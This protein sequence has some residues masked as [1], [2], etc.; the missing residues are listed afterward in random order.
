[1]NKDVLIS[2]NGLQVAEGTDDSVEVVTVGEY[3]NRNDKHYI[4]YEDIDE[5]PKV[6]GYGVAL[7]TF[8]NLRGVD[9]SDVNYVLFDEFCE[10]IKSSLMSFFN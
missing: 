7:S 3:Y 2:I 1:M 10:L 8:E 6:I 5:D 9:L 4:I